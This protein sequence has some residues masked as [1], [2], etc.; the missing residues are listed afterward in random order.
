MNSDQCDSWALPI[1]K[2]GLSQWDWETYKITIIC[3]L[4]LQTAIFLSY[5]LV[6]NSYI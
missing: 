2:D 4:S 5:V 6:I 1:Y 3:L